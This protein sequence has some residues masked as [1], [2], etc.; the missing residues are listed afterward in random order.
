MIFGWGSGI[1]GGFKW[2]GE[3]VGAFE[4]VTVGA[5]LTIT[6]QS[7][8]N[9]TTNIIGEIGFSLLPESETER[10]MKTGITLSLSPEYDDIS[11]E[12]DLEK[13]ITLSLIPSYSADIEAVTE[14][15]EFSITPEYTAIAEPY[16]EMSFSLTPESE[17]DNQT[18]LTGNILLSLRSEYVIE[19]IEYNVNIAE[20]GFS[21]MP[22]A[23]VYG[24]RCLNRVSSAFNCENRVASVWA[25]TTRK[26]TIYEE[27]IR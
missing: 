2:G 17:Y 26:Q 27:A 3:I 5:T 7:A 8:V 25:D 10:V 23:V 4:P 16:T 1:W 13:E 19:D 6:P 24:W 18:N 22:Q 9:V 20:C 12:Y 14:G 11:A 15:V 21:I